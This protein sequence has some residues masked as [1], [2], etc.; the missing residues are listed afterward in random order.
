[1]NH[2]VIREDGMG[3]FWPVDDVK[4]RLQ[5]QEQIKS[6][7][8]QKNSPHSANALLNMDQASER[9]FHDAHEDVDL[10]EHD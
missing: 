2:G 5:L 1:M 4:E 8:K 7:I 10:E 3:R 9:S 6:K